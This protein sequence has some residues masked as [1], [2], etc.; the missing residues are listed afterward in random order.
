M[1]GEVTK[2]DDLVKKSVIPRRN[3]NKDRTSRGSNA[4]TSGPS[5]IRSRSPQ[6]RGRGTSYRKSRGSG[7]AKYGRGNSS[8][9]YGKSD[10]REDD[11][12]DSKSLSRKP[13]SGAKK[14]KGECLSPK[15]FTEAWSSF[16]T[17]AAILLVTSVGLLVANIPALDS[18]PL[19]GRL[20]HCIDGWR[21]ICKNNWV[22]N[23]VEYGY[24]I[25]LKYIP[26]QVGIPSNPNT[27]GPAYDIL[28]RRKVEEVN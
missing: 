23:V 24:K 25:H 27:I 9:Q 11:D 6:D 17:S 21:H 19:G 10:H 16:L 13:K 12:N 26:R 4:G 8:K 2:K 15:S 20:R 22:C 7:G 14:K 5:N 1:L 18:L 28:I 3:P